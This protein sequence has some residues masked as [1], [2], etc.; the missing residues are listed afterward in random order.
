MK[1][2]LNEIELLVANNLK[3]ARK[4]RG[5]TLKQLAEVLDVTQ[6]QVQKYETGGSRIPLD[7][8]VLISKHLKVNLE[9]F[10]KRFEI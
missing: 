1:T 8:L 6:Q 4:I 7:K 3:I 10:V 5:L 2:E 9:F